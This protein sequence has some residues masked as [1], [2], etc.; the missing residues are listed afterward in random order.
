MKMILFIVVTSV[1]LSVQVSAAASP[2]CV[3]LSVSNFLDIGTCLASKGDL[4]S[5]KSAGVVELVKRLSECIFK[6]LAKLEVY[7]Q[8]V[9]LKQFFLYA[10]DRV[11]SGLGNELLEALCDVLSPIVYVLTAGIVQ[12]D[13]HNLALKKKILCDD[14]IKIGVPATLGIGD[15]V[16]KLGEVCVK[17]KPMTTSTFEST[18]R[19]LDCLIHYLHE[20]DP[21]H[22][23]VEVACF[24]SNLP[25]NILGDKVGKPISSSLRD[26]FHVTCH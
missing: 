15:C 19:F 14:P 24:L 10:L 5:S 22:A 18:F 23:Y 11:T 13:C 7:D 16:G 26:A 12:L 9:V 1:V 3:R 4:C 20:T 8:I 17:G 2:E 25:E 21:E 6:G